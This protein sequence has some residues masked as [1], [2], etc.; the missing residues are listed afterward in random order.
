MESKKILKIS[1]IV[2][3]SLIA[4]LLLAVL[5]FMSVKFIQYKSIKE[6]GIPKIYINTENGEKIVSKEDYL[7]CTVTITEADEEYCINEVSAGIRGRGNTSWTSYPKKPYRVKFDEKTSLFGEKANKSWVLLAMYGDFSYMKDRLAFG[8]ADALGTDVFV[9]SYNYVEL[10]LNGKY[11]GLYLLTDQVDENKGRAGVK[12]DFDETATSVPFLVELDAYAPDEG[13]E[14]I[15]WFSVAGHPYNIKYPE[16]DERYTQEQFDYIKNYIETV[17]ALCRKQNVTMAELSEYVD[18]DSFMDYYIVSEVIGQLEINWKSVYMHKTIDGKLKMGPLWDFD[19]SVT[20]SHA[21][22]K[23]RD[24][25]KDNY[26]GL[27]SSGNWFASLLEVSPEF[28]QELSKRF[29]E[30]KVILNAELDRMSIEKNSILKASKKDHLKW[31]W[32]NL[33]KGPEACSDEVVEWCKNRIIW[34]DS[35]FKT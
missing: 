21:Y 5:I 18:M 19:F 9:P 30:A 29:D 25:Y 28:R 2:V 35:F 11:N 34:L 14:G 6:T 12:E 8:L 31:H 33:Y 23:E 20:G 32:F 10:Y 3:L 15:D 4:V 16:A 24:L 27:R 1:L 22:Y 17:D 13:T 7:K 26:E